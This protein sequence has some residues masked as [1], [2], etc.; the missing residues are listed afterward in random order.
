MIG[1]IVVLFTLVFTIQAHAQLQQFQQVVQ[2]GNTFVQAYQQN[3]LFSFIGTV[4]LALLSAWL[5]IKSR[6]GE[7]WFKGGT[8]A[9]ILIFAAILLV[10]NLQGVSFK[11]MWYLTWLVFIYYSGTMK[12][13]PGEKERHGTLA[14]SYLL[15]S[16]F[17][18]PFNSLFG[19]TLFQIANDKISNILITQG[20]IALLIYY[21]PKTW[22]ERSTE[23]K[24]LREKE[25]AETERIAQQDR[26]DKR[27]LQQIEAQEK[28]KKLELQS[29]EKWRGNANSLNDFALTQPGNLAAM[30]PMLRGMNQIIPGVGMPIIQPPQATING[31]QERETVHREVI[32]RQAVIKKLKEDFASTG[33]GREAN[34]LLAIMR[35]FQQDI[36]RR[37]LENWVR[38][39]GPNWDKCEF[40]DKIAEFGNPEYK[41]WQKKM[42]NSVRSGP[43]KAIRIIKGR[44]HELGRLRKEAIDAFSKTLEWINTLSPGVIATAEKS[45]NET[46]SIEELVGKYNKSVE[47][48]NHSLDIAH[49]ALRIAANA[50]TDENKRRDVIRTQLVPSFMKMLELAKE[51]ETGRAKLIPLIKQNE[52]TIKRYKREKMKMFDLASMAE[53][54]REQFGVQLGGLQEAYA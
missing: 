46:N 53:V 21:L 37:K 12:E 38:Y 18:A 48:L 52:E 22:E 42:R 35:E 24:K 40:A 2:A 11:S 47:E 8:A 20:I 15:I 5:I 6:F 28:L 16:I 39:V 10:P 3:N 54:L 17:A 9:V 4:A 29:M 43:H 33:A 41:T 19:E 23:R 44:I 25:K 30:Y 7:A 36:A 32:E 1:L 45:T 31:E 49:E 27:A 14:N 13:N 34:Y 26:E 50:A 51:L